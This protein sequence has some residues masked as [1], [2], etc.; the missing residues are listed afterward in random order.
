MLSRMRLS[1][2]LEIL[3]LH[4][5]VGR[6]LTVLGTLLSNPRKGTVLGRYPFHIRIERN[7]LPRLRI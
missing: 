7:D 1:K 3:C 4:R 6:A 2:V 5:R